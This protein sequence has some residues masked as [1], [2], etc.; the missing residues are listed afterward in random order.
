MRKIVFDIETRNIFQDVGSNN[1]ADLDISVVGIYDY[2]R[3]RYDTFLQEELPR[4]WPILETADLL[5][6]FNN[7][8]FDTPL[9]DK[10]YPGH[11][12]K[13]KN[14]DILKEM[15]KSAGR[16]M[17]LDQIAE[18]TLGLNKSGNGLDAYMW[19]KSGEIEKIKKYCLED[20]RITK[21]IYDYALANSK[22]FFK[23]GG[24]LNEIK[25]DTS[26]WE[27]DVELSAM[28]HTLPF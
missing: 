7:E 10:Y 3:D 23:E 17:K 5:I 11:I 14:V 8:H 24:K 2:E 19:W 20:V 22:L 6:G 15:Q 4:L 1:P 12:S 27:Q 26:L 25:L 28:N 13:I 9:L 16:R 21:E 18:G